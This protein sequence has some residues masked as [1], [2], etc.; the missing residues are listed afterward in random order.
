MQDQLISVKYNLKEVEISKENINALSDKEDE[1]KTKKVS[2]DYKKKEEEK[3]NIENI[4][5]KNTAFQI[6]KTE[7]LEAKE[8][9]NGILHT[10]EDLTRRKNEAKIYMENCN[11]YKKQLDET[12]IKL[13]EKKINKL[14][15]GDDVM[16]IIDE[17]ECKL[18]Q[19]FKDYKEI[20]KENLDKF[21]NSKSEISNLKGNLDLVK[22]RFIVAKNK[23]C[24]EF[25]K[26][27]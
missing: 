7:C 11:N 9:E 10:S 5:D 4:P 15:L 24:R 25:R 14:N 20:Y 19:D 22:D 8:I 1:E 17:E 6:Y 2:E 16:N 23:I 13:N 27:V 26:V 21:K 3:I 18:I 12:K